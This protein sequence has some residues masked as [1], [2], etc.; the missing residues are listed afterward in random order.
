MA[1]SSKLTSISAQLGKKSQRVMFSIKDTEFLLRV[2]G[3]SRIHMREAEQ[4][5][6]TVNKIKTI[7]RKLMEGSYE[8]K[9]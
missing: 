4:A 7:H 9:R 2:L 5:V 6:G 1:D 8:I 3:E